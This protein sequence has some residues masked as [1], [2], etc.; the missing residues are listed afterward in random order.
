MVVCLLTPAL[1]TQCVVCSNNVDLLV[2]HRETSSVCSVLKGLSQLAQG[3]TVRP[4]SH[5]YES[6][7]EYRFLWM[8]QQGLHYILNSVTLYEQLHYIRPTCVI[9]VTELLTLNFLTSVF[10]VFMAKKR[11]CWQKLLICQGNSYSYRTQPYSWI[12]CTIVVAQT[13]LYWCYLTTL[14]ERLFKL[15]RGSSR[16]QDT[17]TDSELQ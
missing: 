12:H 10:G 11:N 7:S 15:W 14:L 9:I 2:K 4:R 6:V 1:L 5:W 3:W 8:G 16:W 17:P 13:A